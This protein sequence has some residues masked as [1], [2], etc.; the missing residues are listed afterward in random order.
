MILN[1]RAVSPSSPFHGPGPSRSNWCAT[2]SRIRPT[3]PP[4]SALASH[5]AASAGRSP[6]S[7]NGSWS[8]VGRW[9]TPNITPCRGSSSRQRIQ[10]ALCRAFPSGS[11]DMP[12][13]RTTS[14]TPP[15]I[16][17]KLTRNRSTPINSLSAFLDPMPRVGPSSPSLSISAQ[18]IVHLSH[19]KVSPL[20]VSLSVSFFHSRI[21]GS[22]LSCYA[23]LIVPSHFSYNQGP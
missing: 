23:V 3:A 1:E 20:C 13:A 8:V 18:V 14:E 5:K 11:H 10:D 16:S 22:M 6:D 7:S 4:C 15:F 17:R 2:R 19:L 12:V 9:D 21:K